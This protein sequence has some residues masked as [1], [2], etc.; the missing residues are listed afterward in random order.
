M[1]WLRSIWRW[2]VGGG[3]AADVQRVR[4]LCQELCGIVPTVG[5]VAAILSASNPAVVGTVAVAV[6]IC[7]AVKG[8]A[9]I[10]ALANF[11][12]KPIVNGVV[13][14]LEVDGK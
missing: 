4:G 9:K 10:K 6:A 11:N 5:S 1:N 14:E 13:V 8:A 7:E 12:T 3:L 2:M